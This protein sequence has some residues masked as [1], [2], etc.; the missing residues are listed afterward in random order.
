MPCVPNAFV[1]TTTHPLISRK[2]RSPSRKEYPFNPHH[3]NSHNIVMT[4]R[5]FLLASLVLS[6]MLATTAAGSN[7]ALPSS[8]EDAKKLAKIATMTNRDLKH[9][10]HDRTANCDGCIERRHLLDRALEVR[11]WLTGD[12]QVMAQLTPIQ[13]SA[14]SHMQMHHIATAVEAG[15]PEQMQIQQRLAMQHAVDTGAVECTAPLAN[16]TVYCMQTQQM[17]PAE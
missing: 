10:L 15:N 9:F 6:A 3:S 5:T 8:E 13:H 14:D 7:M 16:G 11:G 17:G 4:T 1:Q 12:E 2:L